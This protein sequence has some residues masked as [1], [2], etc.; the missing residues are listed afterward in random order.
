MHLQTLFTF[1]VTAYKTRSKR[2]P[3]Q[4]CISQRNNNHHVFIKYL[5]VLIQFQ[6]PHVFVNDTSQLS[7]RVNPLSTLVMLTFLIR[8]KNAQFRNF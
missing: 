6:K 2:N 3:E 8:H 4:K 7:L 1:D 5:H